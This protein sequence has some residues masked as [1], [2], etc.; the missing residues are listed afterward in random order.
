MQNGDIIVV[1]RGIGK[2]VKQ[3]LYGAIGGTR[4]YWKRNIF[5]VAQQRVTFNPKVEWKKAQNITKFLTMVH[6]NK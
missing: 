2:G 5:G 4:A 3:S 1:E 6:A